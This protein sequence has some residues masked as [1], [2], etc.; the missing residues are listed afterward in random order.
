ML[1]TDSI[2]KLKNVGSARRTALAQIGVHT[3]ADLLEYSPREYVDRSIISQIAQLHEGQLATILAWRQGAAQSTQGRGK[4]ITRVNF[5]DGTGQIGITWF[6][7][8]YMAANF[9]DGLKYF[10]SG[11]VVRGLSGRL[12]LETP[13]YEAQNAQGLSA[14]RIVPIYRLT[15]GLTQKMLRGLIKQALDGTKGQI[16]DFLPENLRIANGLCRRDFA[17]EN[18]HFPACGESFYTARKRL[19]FDELFLLQA[20]LMAAKGQLRHETKPF[21]NMDIA[22]ILAALPYELTA[23]QAKVVAE[24]MNDISSG[25]ALNRLLQGD[26][27]SGKTAVAMIICYL[28]AKNGAQA[29]LMAPTETLAVQH[30]ASFKELF[31]GLGIRVGLL[32]GSLK[33]GEKPEIKAKLADGEVDIV[34]GTH[35]LIQENVEFKRLGLVITDEQHRFGVRQRAKLGAKGGAPHILVMTATPIPRSLAMVLYG[36]MDISAIRNLPPGRQKID[37]YTVGKS[38]HP[39][40]FA[41]IRKEIEAG[42][43]AYII[44]PLIESGESEVRGQRSE[45]SEVVKFAEQL[46]SG[47]FADLSLGVLHGRLRS[48]EKNEIMGAFARNE[49]QVLV[50]TTVIEVGINVPN[51][52]VILIENAERFGLSQL[53]QLRGRVGR[54]AHKSYCI[55]I[56]DFKNEITAKRMKAMTS[57]NDGFELSELDLELRGPG[58]FFGTAQHGLPKLMLANLYR[59]LDILEL[60]RNAAL[61]MGRVQ[62]PPLKARIDQ[63]LGK[64][65]QIAL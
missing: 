11:R 22:P 33:A 59:D 3:V 42:R 25:F 61:G 63:L 65:Q 24:I 38:Y 5:S 29:A 4:T 51:A 40:I 10:I 23:D 44:C 21:A 27:G 54:G 50:A 14:G 15:S 47:V 28:T 31:D 43:Q 7:Q 48:E 56:T 35:A 1:L 39:R 34:I 55:L 49:V 52:T 46:K 18:I 6:N 64:M 17:I 32:V 62:F 58:E 30:F 12:T 16:A 53:H 36:D 9:K 41:F 13:E 60:A 19:V 2:E 20:S 37:T 57:T 8:P 26:V 45:I